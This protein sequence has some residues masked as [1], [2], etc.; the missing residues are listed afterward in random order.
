[1]AVGEDTGITPGRRI[2]ARSSCTIAIDTQD[3]AA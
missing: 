2:V 3:F 1:M